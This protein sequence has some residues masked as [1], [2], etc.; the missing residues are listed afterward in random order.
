MQLDDSFVRTRRIITWI[1]VIQVALLILMFGRAPERVPAFL[2]FVAGAQGSV[3]AWI[4]AALTAIAYAWS[5]ASISTVRAYMFKLDGLKAL[6]VLAAVGAGVI[7]EVVFRKLLMDYLLAQGYG[8]VTQVAVS[9]IAFGVVHVVW[10]VKSRAAAVNAVVSTTLLGAALGVVY[11][12]AD[13][14]LAPCVA[15]HVAIDVLI[16]PGLMLAAVQDRLG[17]WRERR[18]DQ[19]S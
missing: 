17:Y 10:G 9:A 18:R 2:G 16:E 14:S 15:A 3:L 7:E 19:A 12:V 1:V 11:L 13:R 5:A 4:L 6:A 8:P